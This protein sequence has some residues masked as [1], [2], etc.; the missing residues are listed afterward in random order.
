[1]ERRR[2]LIIL[3]QIATVSEYKTILCA[4]FNCTIFFKYFLGSR[5][6]LGTLINTPSTLSSISNSSILQSNTGSSFLQDDDAASDI[7]C[8][9]E[10]KMETEGEETDT[11]PEAEA[12]T[13]EGYN[14][15][16]HYGDYVTRCIW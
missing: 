8:G 10:R 6:T 3:L 15:N 7:S 14:Y 11:A 2:D 9:S 4:N 16:D 1:M 5:V 12:V 13:Q